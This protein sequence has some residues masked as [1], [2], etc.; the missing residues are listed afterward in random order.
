MKAFVI[1]FDVLFAGVG[2]SWTDVLLSTSVQTVPTHWK[3]TTLWL[4][5][6][7]TFMGDLGDEVTGTVHYKRSE[8]NERDYVIE[9]FWC[10]TKSGIKSSQKFVLA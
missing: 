2:S 3:Q 9:I 4:T 1:S 6:E 7:N 5:H 10:H 8:A